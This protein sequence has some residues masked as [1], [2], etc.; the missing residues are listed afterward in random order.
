MQVEHST[1]VQAPAARIFRIYE[2]VAAWPSWDPDT[3]RA[4]LDGPFAVGSRGSLTPTQG[5]R[6]PMLVT[7][8]ERNAGF[9]VESRIPL[10]RM[11]FEHELQPQGEAVRVVH[12]VTF[13][14]PLTFVLGRMLARR[15]DQGL[16]VTL[17]RLKRLAESGSA[18]ET[19]GP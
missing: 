15:V 11:V 8:V 10:F 9:T 2:D 17:A 13:S 14:G 7:K 19:A 6:V 1:V 18:A 5:R 4:A 3:R 12:R 16:P